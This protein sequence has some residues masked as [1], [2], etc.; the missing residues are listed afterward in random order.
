MHN[1]CQCKLHNRY[2]RIHL[3]LHLHLPMVRL[4]KNNWQT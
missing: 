4:L 1:N 2:K 3:H